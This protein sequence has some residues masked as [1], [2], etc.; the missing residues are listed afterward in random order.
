MCIR[1][2]INSVR[3]AL[4]DPLVQKRNMVV[5]LEQPSGSTA[6]MPGN[7]IKFDNFEE[8]YSPAPELGQHTEE[9][10]QEY[11]GL[12]S[13]ELQTLKEEKII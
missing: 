5:E 7:P 12:D 3:D 6:E 10:L 8:N 9:I 4:E 2:S 13:S 11:I 1:D